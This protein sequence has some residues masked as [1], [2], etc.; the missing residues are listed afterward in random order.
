M[1][2]RI[3]VYITNQIIFDYFNKFNSFQVSLLNWMIETTR[4]K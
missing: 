1:I 4:D 2:L 3:K